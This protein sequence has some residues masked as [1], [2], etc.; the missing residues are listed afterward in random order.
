MVACDAFSIQDSLPIAN[1]DRTRGEGYNAVM[2]PETAAALV[3]VNRTF[4]EQ[5][6]DSFAATRQR[7]QPGILRLFNTYPV[8]GHWLDLGCGNGAVLSAWAEKSEHGIY[9]GLDFSQALLREAEQRA[10]AVRQPAMKAVLAQADISGGQWGR[11]LDALR[12]QDAPLPVQFDGVM[13]FASIHHIPGRENRSEF[14]GQVNQVLKPG[15][16]VFLSCWQFQHSPK[17]LSRV[18]S[19]KLVNIDPANL[20]EGDTLLD[21]RAT[22]SPLAGQAGLRY[23]HLF[24]QA[25]LQA[26]ALECGYSIEETFESDG[27]GGR[28]G[29]YQ[30]W[31]KD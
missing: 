22:A 12:A 28:L 9:T 17:L 15:G 8:H 3:A 25:E 21:W 4:Y 5:F 20:E 18:Q 31:R 1:R 26:L 29:L 7:V 23:V 19:W 10:Q 30:V 24:T 14:F 27:T 2:D 11:A 16:L 13:S 6:G